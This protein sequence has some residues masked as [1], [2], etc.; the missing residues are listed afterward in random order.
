MGWIDHC[1][2][3]H[4]YPLGFTGA[5]VRDQD[6]GPGGGL[7]RIGHWLD[8]AVELGV[9]G[10][11]L[12]PVF[13]S[14]THGYDSVDQFRIDPRLGGLDDLDDLVAACKARGLRVLLDGVFNHVG[15]GHPLVQQAL[16]EG[17]DGPYAS[18]FRIDWDAPG[19]VQ[20]GTFEG[21]D[22]L[23]ALNHQSP[24]VAD[25]VTSVMDY[26]LDRGVDGWRLDAAYAVAPEFWA[27]VLPAV[28]GRHPDAWFVG[29][30]IHG[31]YAG[32]VAASGMDSVTQYEL[33]KAT[34]SSIVDRNFFELDWTLSRHNELLDRFVPMTFV[35]NHDVSRIASTAGEA[36][37]VLA[38]VILMTTG[39]VPSIYYG[40]EQA[41]TGVKED[42]LGGDDAV[43]PAFP[44]DPGALPDRGRWMYRIHQELI[45][46]RR[47]HPWL[48]TAQTTTVSLTNT[49]Y[50]YEARAAQGDGWLRVELDVADGP[51]ARVLD[52]DGN[53]VFAFGG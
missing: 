38:L 45:G 31:E 44:D 42:R 36:G 10:L 15:S 26:W 48:V 47:R 12:G 11:S 7:A 33:W 6:A 49:S 27:A 16:R 43:R 9:S 24:Q 25:Y 50:V 30:V 2:W 19:G 41:F 22:S 4:V 13:A 35:G 14:Q 18:F 29:E 21:H 39:G 3:W 53:V 37:A 23:V 17:P 20:V 28:R 34:W 1:V 8:Y 5:P 40:D 32:L 46:L 52:N 51:R